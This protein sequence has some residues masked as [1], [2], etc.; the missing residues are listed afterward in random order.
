MSCASLFTRWCPV[1]VSLWLPRETQFKELIH[2]SLWLF[3]R[4]LKHPTSGTL[5]LEGEPLSWTA[6]FHEREK[7]KATLSRT[8]ISNSPF[9]LTCH[10]PRF[11]SFSVFHCG[12]INV[13]LDWPSFWQNILKEKR[14]ILSG[15][16]QFGGGGMAWRESMAECLSSQWEH[17]RWYHAVEADRRPGSTPGSGQ[18]W[19]TPRSYLRN[20]VHPAR[21]HLCKF[22]ELSGKNTANCGPSFPGTPM[23]GVSD[24]ECNAVS[25]IR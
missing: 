2:T 13:M 21:L 11:F 4:F 9:F 19:Y 5:L 12:S 14:F 8:A 25:S 20:T 24:A 10:T 16:C 15:A 23:V 18:G 6:L 17:A 7:H 1:L 22:L 3:Q